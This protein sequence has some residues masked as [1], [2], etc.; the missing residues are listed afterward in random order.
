M[1]INQV[2]AQLY[3]ARKH[4]QTPSDLADCLKKL[5]TIGYE[6]VQVSSLGP[7]EPK[8]LVKI[9]S[10]AGVVICS[11]HDNSDEILNDPQKVADRLSELG[12]D[13]TV[14]AHPD[15]IDVSVPANVESLVK[16]LEH[17]GRVLHE[18]GKVLC[19]HNHSLEFI[20]HNDKQ[21]VLE[22]IFDKIDPKYLQSEIDTYWVQHG[23]CD[24]VDWM[25]RLKNRA[26]IMHLKDYASAKGQPVIC[27][28]G[29][30]NLNF[31]KIIAAAESSGCKWFAVEQDFPEDAFESLKISFDYIK[32]NLVS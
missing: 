3:T 8:E 31:K 17:S 22:Y 19:Y 29:R 12:V 14:Y 15:G 4:T 20:R 27:E 9:A 1:K 10:D 23:G 18:A 30:G 32:E 2:A 16:R 28:I 5:R 25:L 26:P 6:V 24:P 11:L 21:L 13:T 7:I